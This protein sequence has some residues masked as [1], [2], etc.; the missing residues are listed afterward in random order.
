MATTSTTKSTQPNKNSKSWVAHKNVFAHHAQ[1]NSTKPIHQDT[2]P[3]GSILGLN[4]QVEN[5]YLS[6]WHTLGY[7]GSRSFITFV[8]SYTYHLCQI[9]HE[10]LI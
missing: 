6:I 2:V 4:V 8:K 1:T 9:P 7:V 10:T 5:K 3:S